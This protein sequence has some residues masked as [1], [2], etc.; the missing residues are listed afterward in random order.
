MAV[1]ADSVVVDLIAN[2]DKADANM[3]RYAQT[4]DSTTKTIETSS[5][6]A[7]NAVVKMSDRG[8]AAT[9]NFGR[10]VSDVGVQLGG[11]A[12][13]F[14]II[15]QQGPQVIDALDE[16]KAAGVGFGTALKGIAL[17]GI[18]AVASAMLPLVTNLLNAGEAGKAAKDGTDLFS[19]SLVDLEARAK[20][21]D[22]ALRSLNETSGSRRFAAMAQQNVDNLLAQANVDRIQGE[23]DKLSLSTGGR[24]ANFGGNYANDRRAESMQRELQANKDLLAQGQLRLTLMQ[25]ANARIEAEDAG[26]KRAVATKATETRAR[27]ENAKAIETEAAMLA[28][29]RKEDDASDRDRTSAIDAIRNRPGG[30]AE[31]VSDSDARLAE[32][33]KAAIDAQRRATDELYRN[34]E[35]QIRSLASIYEDAFLGGTGSIWQ[36]FEREGL[37][38]LALLLAKF[39]IL[40]STKG[41]SIGGNLSSAFSSVAGSFFGR[42]SGGYTAGGQTVRVNESA[43]P[44]RV[45]GFRPLGAGHIIPLGQMNAARPSGGMTIAPNITIDARGAT[46]PAQIERIAR[47]ATAQG[48]AEAAPLLVSAANGQT[49][50]NIQRPRLPGSLG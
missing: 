39:T 48:I 13:P 46:D 15:V 21:A 44:G 40:Q 26:S 12:S 4:F 37:R 10:Q 31:Q 11:G 49:M 7:E 43:A 35:D 41:G 42:A 9:R 28:R 34:E 25:K 18:L 3:R 6:R 38:V 47:A 17:P 16:M 50:R 19:N 33:R 29:L 1:T 32:G 2:V 45:E 27:V 5:Q 14:L 36:T 24:A 22:N 20:D 23:I 30:I 8:A